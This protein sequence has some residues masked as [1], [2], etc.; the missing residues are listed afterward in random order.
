MGSFGIILWKSF[1]WIFTVSALLIYW[2]HSQMHYMPNS[3]RLVVVS[4][5]AG[6]GIAMMTL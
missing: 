4:S 5:I 1:W 3:K 6:V 2:K